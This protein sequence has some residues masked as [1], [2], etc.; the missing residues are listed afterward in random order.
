MCINVLL[1]LNTCKSEKQCSGIFIIYILNNPTKFQLNW[2]RTQNFH[3]KLF[4]IAAYLLKL[5]VWNFAQSSTKKKK[6]KK[7]LVEQG[8]YIGK[9]RIAFL[10]PQ[11][12]F[13]TSLKPTTAVQYESNLDV[14]S[15]SNLLCG[16]MGTT[17]TAPTQE[18]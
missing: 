8:L 1:S 9:Q 14:P 18:S 16:L 6:K 4:D 15:E 5:E 2:I 17:H 11:C 3:L 7:S 12:S 13:N 10:V